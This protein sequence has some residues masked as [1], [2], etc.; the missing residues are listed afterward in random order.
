MNAQFLTRSSLGVWQYVLIRCFVSI[1]TLVF[2]AL[3][4]YDEGEIRA[5]RF[6]VYGIFFINL[7]QCWA[8]YCL[9]IFYVEL[10]DELAPIRPLGKFLVV[11]A[12]VFFSWWQHVI[13]AMCASS[14]VIQ[15]MLG[16]SAED[17][18][19]GWQNLLIVVE[20]FVYAVILKFT[21]SYM[22]FR[23]GDWNCVA[24]ISVAHNFVANTYFYSLFSRGSFPGLVKNC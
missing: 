16:Y 6:Y 17:V 5:D 15:P 3:H 11:K 4:L 12:V 1:L 18:A 19:K 14:N 2:H 23:A 22:D 10:K 21:F 13:V 8:L 20:M 7:S 9:V 24:R